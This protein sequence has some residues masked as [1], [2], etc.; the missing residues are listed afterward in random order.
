MQY[1]QRHQVPTPDEYGW[2]QYRG[3]NGQPLE[4]QRPLLIGPLLTGS[5]A[6]SI[7]DGHFYGK[8]IMLGSTM[9]VQAY[10]WS[11]DWYRKQAEA[12]LGANFQNS[13]RIWYMDNADHD[14]DGPAADHGC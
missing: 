8:M 6:G 14:P 12:A 7:P 4:P 2:N 10:P 5:T 13:Y 11:E 9:D 1:Y 3:P